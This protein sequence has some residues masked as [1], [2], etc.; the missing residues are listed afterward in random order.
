MK[1]TSL[2]ISNFRAFAELPTTQLGQI[3]VLIGPNNV[4]KSSVLRALY[5]VQQ[6]MSGLFQ[7]VRI[8]AERAIIQVGIEEAGDSDP[9]AALR[10]SQGVV[11]VT[12]TPKRPQRTSGNQQLLLE[13]NSKKVNVNMLQ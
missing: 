2:S 11:T 13:V 8:G 5:S 4:G 12:V 9:W 1:V 6:G 7:D 10:D 3:N